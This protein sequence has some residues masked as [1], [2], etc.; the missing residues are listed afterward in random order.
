MIST[1]LRARYP[2]STAMRYGRVLVIRYA[3]L[4]TMEWSR[5]QYL[6]RLEGDDN[7][8]GLWNLGVSM[9]ADDGLLHFDDIQNT[10]AI[11]AEMHRQSAPAPNPVQDTHNIVELS[12]RQTDSASRYIL[13]FSR[14]SSL[15]SLL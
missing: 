1:I 5:L 12:D 2:Y 7:L 4:T 14:Y 11:R 13:H 10:C 9:R 15:P 6:T 8:G 3:M